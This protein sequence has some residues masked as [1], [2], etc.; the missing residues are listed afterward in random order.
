MMSFPII[1]TLNLG[2]VWNKHSHKRSFAFLVRDYRDL[3]GHRYIKL[4]IFLLPLISHFNQT[5]QSYCA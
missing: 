1:H 2:I 3:L 4:L 5:F